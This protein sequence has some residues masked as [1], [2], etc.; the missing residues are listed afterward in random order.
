MQ[1]A[2]ARYRALLARHG[3]R[4]T[5]QRE[6]IYAALAASH[7]H[8]TAEELLRAVR[9]FQP[10]LSLATVYNTLETFTRAGLCR[11]VCMSAA[12][13]ACRYDADLSD[14]LHAVTPDGRVWDIPSDLGEA[15]LGHIPEELIRQIEERMGVRIERV[16]V[17]FLVAPPGEGDG[18]G[19]ARGR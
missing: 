15:V 8:P 12:G 9:V 14:H 6:V 5:R 10:G 3:I 1:D 18:A 4:A 13:G 7:E 2:S 11:K 19:D 16:S 17:D